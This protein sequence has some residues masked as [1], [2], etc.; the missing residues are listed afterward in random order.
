MSFNRMPNKCGVAIPGKKPNNLLSDKDVAI[1]I[2]LD[3][4]PDIATEYCALVHIK[5]TGCGD[6]S[7]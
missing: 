4:T 2:S 5:I 3:I 7:P 6:D 1:P